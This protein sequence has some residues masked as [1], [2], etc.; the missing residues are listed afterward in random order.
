MDRDKYLIEVVE[1]LC[2]GHER[3]PTPQ[4]VEQLPA[5][6]CLVLLEGKKEKDCYVCSNRSKD[7][8]SSRGRSRSRY[9]CPACQVGC[10]QKCAPQLEHVTNQGERKRP[11]RQ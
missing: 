4:P 11:R 1:A 10:H 3:V 6:H 5:Q 8:K 9:W 7:K 2:E